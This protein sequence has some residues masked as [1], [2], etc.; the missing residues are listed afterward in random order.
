MVKKLGNGIEKEM[1]SRST[2]LLNKQKS[3]FARGGFYAR[4]SSK[5]SGLKKRDQ[6]F[7]T[8]IKGKFSG[9]NVISAAI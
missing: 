3:K 8:Q 1:G 5:G 6:V 9:A 2:V 4:E 7:V